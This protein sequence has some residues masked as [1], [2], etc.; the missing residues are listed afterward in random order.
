MGFASL[1]NAFESLCPEGIGAAVSAGRVNDLAKA[2]VDSM[3][4]SNLPG[5]TRQISV[6]P[7]TKVQ[8]GFTTSSNDI[9]ISDQWKLKFTIDIW[10]HVAN[11]DSKK[12]ITSRWQFTGTQLEPFVDQQAGK[13]YLQTAPLGN[14]PKPVSDTR[15]PNADQYLIDIGYVKGGAPDWARFNEEVVY[16]FLRVNSRGLLAGIVRAIPLP[17]V[18]SFFK[19][20]TPIPPI[21]AAIRDGYLLCWTENARINLPLCDAPPAQMQPTTNWKSNGALPQS[22]WD[23]SSPP[24][25]LY[26]AA[27]PLLQ[28][29]STGL[30]PAVMISK[31]QEG[32]IGWSIDAAAGLKSLEITLVA[33]PAGGEITGHAELRI[34]GFATAWMNGPCGV[35]LDVISAGITAD[36]S[37][38]AKWKIFSEPAS[39]RIKMML[40]VN[41]QIDRGSINIA[42]GGLI[43]VV[44]GDL[45]EAL[46]KT[47]LIEINTD[48]RDRTESVLFDA[49]QLINR[50][51]NVFR[52]VG[53][54]SILCGLEEV[55]D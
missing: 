40:D 36:G 2:A 14:P 4:M 17:Q 18:F 51:P 33:N 3:M 12:I 52:R 45:I 5:A 47:G 26:I 49:A 28:W 16:P 23:A 30:M 7:L 43:G 44:L 8:A 35:R 6:Y 11:N 46:I 38:D 48:Y 55:A 54:R 9:S 13:V 31:E 27:K 39:K 32:F 34:L 22:P 20:V 1:H 50:I 29:Y 19:T 41:G 15:D 42:G 53:N 37:L 21:E 24:T 10:L 25:A